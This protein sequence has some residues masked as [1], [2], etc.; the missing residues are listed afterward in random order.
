[1][2]DPKRER[3]VGCIVWLLQEREG[4]EDS[5]LAQLLVYNGSIL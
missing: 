1:M 5:G 3:S 2:D 4:I